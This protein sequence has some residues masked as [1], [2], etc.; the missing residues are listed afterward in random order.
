MKCGGGCKVGDKPA[1]DRMGQRM[2][3]N[4]RAREPNRLG[5]YRNESIGEKGPIDE[6]EGL[7]S[8]V[9]APNDGQFDE[10]GESHTI[11]RAKAPNGAS[12]N[13]RQRRRIRA[14]DQSSVQVATPI[15]SHRDRSLRHRRC[16]R[17]ILNGLQCIQRSVGRTD[18]DTSRRRREGTRERA[19]P[20]TPHDAPRRADAQVS[21]YDGSARAGPMPNSQ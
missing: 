12:A 14:H 17:D 8:I 20:A 19:R 2:R 4:G 3:A 5:R 13:E 21:R 16:R 1:L 7:D 15:G 11:G 10:P 9:P 6:T 18:R